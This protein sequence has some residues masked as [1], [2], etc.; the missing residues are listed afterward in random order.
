MR[1]SGRIETSPEFNSFSTR[2]VTLST[3]MKVKDLTPDQFLSVPCPT[4]G[5]GALQPCVNHMGEARSESHL[6][7]K[8]WVVEIVKSNGMQRLEGRRPAKQ[9]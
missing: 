9:L 3:A 6:G 4:C 2:F 7:R 1:N 8:L 5:V